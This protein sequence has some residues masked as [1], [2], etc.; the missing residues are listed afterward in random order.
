MSQV[1]GTPDFYWKLAHCQAQE[2]VG[3]TRQLEE[4]RTSNNK[5]VKDNNM[6]VNYNAKL[7]KVNNKLV[8]DNN[9]LVIEK[10]EVVDYN[11]NLVEVNNKLVNDNNKLVEDNTMLVND[12]NKLVKDNTKLLEFWK[13]YE[14][15][16]RELR[17]KLYNSGVEQVFGGMK[18][19]P[20]GKVKKEEAEV[21][22]LVSTKSDAVKDVIGEEEMKKEKLEVKEEYM[23][24]LFGETKEETVEEKEVALP[25]EVGLVSKDRKM[26]RIRCR[27]DLEVFDDPE[28]K[29]DSLRTKKP[30]LGPSSWGQ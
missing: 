11:T 29:S 18:E 14:R 26:E 30:R 9:K 3:A 4:L 15:E 8:N 27:N 24:K 19:D 28:F 12:N 5:L 13:M 17:I 25:G 23:E 2:L 10:T 7:M 16:N 21:K 1:P 22:E 6:L 20:G